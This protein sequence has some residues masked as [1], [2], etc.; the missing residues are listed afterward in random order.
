MPAVR[1]M[2]EGDYR[3][4]REMRINVMWARLKDKTSATL[5]ADLRQMQERGNF[6]VA[7][8]IAAIR[9]SLE[10]GQK[11]SDIG[12]E[13]LAKILDDRFEYVQH[14]MREGRL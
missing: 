10:P 4:W 7:G 5:L 13:R 9:A 12:R 6:T 8:D 3:R 1:A 11:V 2:N 14:E